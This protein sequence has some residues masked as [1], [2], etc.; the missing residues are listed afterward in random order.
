MN[1]TTC[2]YA[3]ERY[4]RDG[5]Q[6]GIDC[7]KDNMRFIPMNIAEVQYCG[8]YA[9]RDRMSVRDEIMMYAKAYLRINGDAMPCDIVRSY[10]RTHPE[11][12][13]RTNEQALRSALSA[14]V[15]QGIKSWGPKAE[16]L[17][18]GDGFLKLNEA[19]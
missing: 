12:I 18:R 11:K 19:V 3:T 7:G 9:E 6:I 4:D 14:G 5:V 13:R 10:M 16:I 8:A 1:C 2:Y 15:T 17:R